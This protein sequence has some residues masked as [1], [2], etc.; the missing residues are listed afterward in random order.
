MDRH[1][2]RTIENT[3]AGDVELSEEEKAVVW[4][5]VNHFDV[6]GD[7]SFG[8]PAAELRLWG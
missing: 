6:K 3:L 7:R 5:I 1:P 2:N 4:D 8:R